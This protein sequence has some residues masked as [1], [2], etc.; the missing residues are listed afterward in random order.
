MEPPPPGGFEMNLTARVESFQAHLDRYR[1]DGLRPFATSSFQSNSVVLLHL[2]SRFGPEVPVYFLDTGY[3]FPETLAFRDRLAARL[4]L[5]VRTLRSPIS[6]E[7][8]RDAAGRLLFCSDPDRCCELNKV[9][10]LEPITAGYDVW[11]S[12]LRGSQSAH[13]AT[14]GREEPGRNG[15]LRYHPLIDWDARAVHGYIEE[16]GLP[17][18]PLEAEGYLSVGCQPCTRKA[19][20]TGLDDRSGR[21]AGQRKTE[22]GLHLDAG[23]PAGE[24]P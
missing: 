15:V 4:G 20:A 14:L 9:L 6:R 10:P 2:L 12:G 21:W 18:H 19:L 16:H 8:Q 1:S 7:L 13:R 3:H 24:H 5:D 22:C 11:I 23:D 17:R